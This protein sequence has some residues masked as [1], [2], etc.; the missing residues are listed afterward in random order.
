MKGTLIW[1]FDGTLANRP[2]TWSGSVLLALDELWPGHSIPIESIRP[3]M[4]KHFPW[5]E[6][7]NEYHHMRKP[8]KWWEYMYGV[9]GRAFEALGLP[10]HLKD[11]VVRRVHHHVVD[12]QK[13]KLFPDVN[14]TLCA[15]SESGW[16]HVILSNNYPEL[17]AV[18]EGMSAHHHFDQIYTS[19]TIGYEKPRLEI[20][21]FVLGQL[22]HNKKVWMIGDSLKADVVGAEAAGIPSILVR[23]KPE[24]S[25]PRYAADLIAARKIIT[26]EEA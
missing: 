14:E 1:D 17:P 8:E 21:Q 12:H 10:G 3:H 20:F 19:A 18:V 16:N 9:L 22:K 25:A 11:K 13:Y 24:P 26:V 6:P 2:L 5:H 7:E 23:V 15:L 4:A